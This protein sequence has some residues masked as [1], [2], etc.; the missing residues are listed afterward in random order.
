MLVLVAA[1][2]H[3]L[4]QLVHK[5]AHLILFPSLLMIPVDDELLNHQEAS[6]MSLRSATCFYDCNPTTVPNSQLL[7]LLPVPK[8][9]RLQTNKI[10]CSP[11]LRQHG[12][13][14]SPRARRGPRSSA[15]SDPR[16]WGPTT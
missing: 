3:V 6:T 9:V 16:R 11:M 15:L 2:D 8:L 5:P 1:I 7:S 14:S 12:H 10:S 13:G 4:N